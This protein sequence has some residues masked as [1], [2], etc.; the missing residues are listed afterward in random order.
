[1]SGS[2]I[3]QCNTQAFR[4]YSGAIEL[5]YAFFQRCATLVMAGKLRPC[6]PDSSKV[7]FAGASPLL[8]CAWKSQRR[9]WNYG[10]DPSQS[11]LLGISLLSFQ[12]I[13]VAKDRRSVF[14][15]PIT[16]SGICNPGQSCGPDVVKHCKTIAGNLLY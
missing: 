15:E 11:Q 9:E 14:R 3:F 1:M 6:I 16:P 8:L 12:P 7:C 4:Y 2:Y 10:C 5:A 13:I